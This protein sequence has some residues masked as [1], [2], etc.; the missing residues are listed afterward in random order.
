MRNYYRVIMERKSLCAGE[1]Y[2][3][4]F[5]GTHFDIEQDLQG[6]FPDEWR[7]FN[8]QFVSIL[9]GQPSGQVQGRGWAGMR[10]HGPDY[11]QATVLR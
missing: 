6:R 7:P 10:L 1:C 2:A 4:E 3:R 9:P 11:S 8:K 5:F